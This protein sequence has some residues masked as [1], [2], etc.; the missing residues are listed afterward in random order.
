M[1]TQATPRNME[2]A[3]K[4]GKDA[5]ALNLETGETFSASTGDYWGYDIDEPLRDDGGQPLVL[6]TKAPVAYVDAFTCLDIQL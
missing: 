5:V 3:Q 2:I 6:A 1:Y 4:A